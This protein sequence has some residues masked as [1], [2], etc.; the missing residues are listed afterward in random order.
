MNWEAKA[1]K[2]KGQNRIAVYFEKN[3]D[4][5]TRIKKLQD[6]RWSQ[7]FKAWHLP[8]NEENR[9]RFKINLPIVLN[10][11]HIK[12]TEQFKRWLSSKRY[13][14]NTIKTYT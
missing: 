10:E 11:N 5:I 9:L 14:P 3:A 8:D 1:V 6:A 2:H 7:T 12:K 13:S 4:L